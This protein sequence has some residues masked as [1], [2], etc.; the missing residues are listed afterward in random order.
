MR[1]FR[2]LNLSDLKLGLDDLLTKRHGALVQSNVGK[3]YE[4]MLAHRRDAIDALPPALGG[5]PLAD[6]LSAAD[7]DHDG[8]GG[9]I[10]YLTEAYLRLPAAAPGVLDAV[11]RVRAALIPEL[12]Q[13]R[14]S[15]AD[16]AEAAIRR[17]AELPDLKADLELIPVAGGGSLHD[18]AVAFLGAGEKLSALLSQRA[19]VDTNGRKGAQHLR[20]E[21][22]GMLN[23]LRNAIADETRV[24]K[25][26]KD[27]DAQIFGYLDDLEAQRAAALRAPK[28]AKPEAPAPTAEA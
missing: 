28:P 3:S 21:T 25:L 20:S 1:R 7:T 5:K 8:F 6:A 9:A 18:W 13:L 17:K 4:A 22:V 23:R 14:D 19:D 24:G 12:D 11:R 10:Y 2:V 16:E 27:L 15:Y 26:P